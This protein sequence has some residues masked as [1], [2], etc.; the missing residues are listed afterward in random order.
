MIATRELIERVIVILVIFLFVLPGCWMAEIEGTVPPPSEEDYGKKSQ[1]NFSIDTKKNPH[2]LYI[3]LPNTA[4]AKD[5]VGYTCTGKVYI[6]RQ[7]FAGKD[8]L[9]LKVMR[10]SA[11]DNHVAFRKSS[12]ENLVVRDYKSNGHY[13]AGWHWLR[14][15]SL[16]H[17]AE[18][19]IT[20]LPPGFGDIRLD[21]TVLATDRLDGDRGCNAYFLLYYQYGQ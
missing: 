11:D 5:P 3:K 20:D 12:I 9:Y 1:D 4:Q 13:I 19:I 15:D 2:C 7:G 8:L 17:Y 16:A 10:A 18:W 6:P 14:D 21:L